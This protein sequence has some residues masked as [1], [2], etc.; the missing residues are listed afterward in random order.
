[1][2]VHAQETTGAGDLALLPPFF[3]LFLLD[4]SLM[5]AGH[6]QYRQQTGEK[7]RAGSGSG[8]GGG[9]VMK[10]RST[11]FRPGSCA[12]PRTKGRPAGALPPLSEHRTPRAGLHRF[13][14]SPSSQQSVHPTDRLSS[15]PQAVIRRFARNA[16]WRTY[17]TQ[18]GSGTG[19]PVR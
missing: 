15:N 17:R 18:S 6:A 8:G 1:M 4:F 2:I 5:I 16:A 9:A 7:R 19:C 3:L 14:R 10:N 11:L 12:A 13:P